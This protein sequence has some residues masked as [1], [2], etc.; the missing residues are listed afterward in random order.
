MCRNAALASSVVASMTIVLPWTNP[1]SPGRSSTQVEEG[2]LGFG[3]IVEPV[4]VQQLI[5]ARLD[6]ET[7]HL[8]P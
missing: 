7:R 6:R 2:T 4:L 3:E 5:Q 1:A 8:G